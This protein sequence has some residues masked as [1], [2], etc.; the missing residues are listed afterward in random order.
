MT[1]TPQSVE[2]LAGRVRCGPL[3]CGSKSE[4]EA[5]WLDTGAASY[6]LRR[7]TGP[8]FGDEALGGLIG[9]QVACWGFLLDGTLLAVRI[10]LID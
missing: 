5:V 8:A 1:A 7:K 9:R 10:E 6:V 4:R 2:A 3:G